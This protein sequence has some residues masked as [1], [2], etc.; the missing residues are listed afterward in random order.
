MNFRRGKQMIV[1]DTG[2]QHL[3]GS[4]MS[5]GHANLFQML[6]GNVGTIAFFSC[7][8]GGGAWEGPVDVY[9]HGT[10]ST[11]QAHNPFRTEPVLNLERIIFE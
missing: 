7:E 3:S 1:L 10:S 6:R 5:E 2:L 9:D 8:V 11:Y 4:R